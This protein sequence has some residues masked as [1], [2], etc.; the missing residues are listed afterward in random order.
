MADAN[1]REIERGT[2]FEV[3]QGSMCAQRIDWTRT[4]SVRIIVVGHASVDVA[5][6]II[7]RLDSVLRSKVRITALYDLWDTNGYESGVRVELTKWGQKH[8]ADVEMIHFLSRSKLANMAVS[9]VA[10][11]MPGLV[12]GYGK[13]AEFDVLAR[14]LGFPLNPP[15]P[16]GFAPSA[17]L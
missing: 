17:G 16:G 7:R 12:T 5:E 14:K 6:V 9:V 4:G 1:F 11:A 3:H 10:L 15:M 2:T 13:R 8:R